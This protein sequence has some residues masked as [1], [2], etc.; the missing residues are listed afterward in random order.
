MSEYINLVNKNQPIQQTAPIMSKV[1][2]D[3][4]KINQTD[5][6]EKTNENKKINKKKVIKIGAI[7]S[8]AILA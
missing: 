1:Q 3:G 5:S 6:F 8:A 4:V 7:I 2:N